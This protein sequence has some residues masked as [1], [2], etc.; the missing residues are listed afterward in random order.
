MDQPTRRR[1]RQAQPQRPEQPQPQFQAGEAQERFAGG[2]DKHDYTNKQD[3]DLPVGSRRKPLPD[4]GFMIIT[5]GFP[6]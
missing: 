5:D 3:P 2:T 1:S 6:E 4:G